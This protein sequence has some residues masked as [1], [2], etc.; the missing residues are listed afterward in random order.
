V[1]E[2][3]EKGD[4]MDIFSEKVW[5]E[6]E[7]IL[8]KKLVEV[9]P[10]G[11]NEEGFV[12]QLVKSLEEYIRVNGEDKYQVNVEQFIK[13]GGLDDKAGRAEIAVVEKQAIL[14]N[15]DPDLG[16]NAWWDPFWTNLPIKLLME[17]KYCWKEKQVFKNG[18]N[19]ITGAGTDFEKLKKY[20]IKSNLPRYAET[21]GIA[22]VFVQGLDEDKMNELKSQVKES[23]D[24]EGNGKVRI[25]LHDISK[26]MNDWR[27]RAREYKHK[28]PAK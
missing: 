11:F 6:I 12:F 19:L 26:I 18:Y 14:D 15:C 17:V 27:D 22:F 16:S 21:K 23:C 24:N 8:D 20:I 1:F 5:K 28:G 3:P 13:I 25:E 9:I 7:S 2:K 4:S 10:I